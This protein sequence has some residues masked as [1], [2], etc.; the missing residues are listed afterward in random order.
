MVQKDP[1]GEEA[2][3]VRGIVQESTPMAMTAREVERVSEKDPELCSVRYCIQ[4]GDWSQCKMPHYLS[5]KNE[6]CTIGK[7]VMRGTRIVIPQSLRSEVLR[8]AHE[9]HQG[10]MKMKTHLRSKV[11]WPKTDS[12]AEKVC[13]SC[14]RCQVVGEFCPPEPM[15]RVE[16]PSGPWQDVA[17]DVLGPLPSGESLLVVVDYYSRFFEV[18]VMR[19]TT[20]QKMIET[21]MPIFTWYGYPFSLKSEN[22]PQFVSEEF[23]VFLTG[24][25]IEHRKSTPLWP[26]ANG[27]VERQNRT[28]L[29][30]LK[31][32][33]AEGKR[34]KEEL[35]KFLLAYRT[36][37][38]SS[39]GA[40][41]AFLMFG[42]ELKTK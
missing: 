7:L 23:K 6:L 8:L 31:I 30:S 38:H 40:T 14:P 18:V 32:A 3:F 42:R 29:K 35:N 37:P 11:W 5:V 36:T 20:S 19:T 34:W 9:G 26:Q 39:T 17:I 21:L 41:P 24:H 16:P 28:L 4:S 25:G 22:A 33:D 2:D 1:S 15:Q 12:D 10:I 13:R 27:K